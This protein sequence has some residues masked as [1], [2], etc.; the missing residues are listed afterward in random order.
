MTV[1]VT[2]ALQMPV[3]R[4]DDEAADSIVPGHQIVASPPTSSSALT[5]LHLRRGI[6]N[7][8]WSLLACRSTDAS[9]VS[10]MGGP[11]P[12]LRAPLR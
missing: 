12:P 2:V 3:L 11:S 6:K 8:G 10:A 1:T 7:D 9:P 5:T 4:T